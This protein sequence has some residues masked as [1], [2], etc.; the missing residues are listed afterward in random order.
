MRWCGMNAVR[1][2][3]TSQRPNCGVWDGDGYEGGME[4]C[5]WMVSR[6]VEVKRRSDER[7]VDLVAEH[8]N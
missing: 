5:L 6:M 1:K 8:H 4:G 2:P 7:Q 3:A